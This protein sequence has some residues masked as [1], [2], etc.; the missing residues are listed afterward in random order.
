MDEDVDEQIRSSDDCEQFSS[1]E[2]AL[3]TIASPADSL[4][5]PCFSLEFGF[6]RAEVSQVISLPDPASKSLS[7]SMRLDFL[8]CL[9]EFCLVN[10]GEKALYLMLID[11]ARTLKF[12]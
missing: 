10:F 12:E 4:I 3:E 11:F 6:K 9:T 5:R 8:E 1:S 7:K 2:L